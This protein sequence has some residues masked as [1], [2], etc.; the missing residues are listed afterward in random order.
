MLGVWTTPNTP[1]TLC[2]KAFPAIHVRC[3]QKS[4]ITPFENKYVLKGL[5]LH[6]HLEERL[7]YQ[8]EN[9]CSGSFIAF[10]LLNSHYFQRK[11]EEKAMF[12][13]II[14]IFLFYLQRIL[15]LINIT[16]AFPAIHV[17]CQQKTA[18]SYSLLYFF[19]MSWIIL[20]ISSRTLCGSKTSSFSLCHNSCW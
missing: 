18:M 14:R 15:I 7:Y 2:T 19:S 16:K 5:I 20:F 3:Q 17:R 9:G 13:L 11:H 1:Q 10:F 4:A 6:R 8:I 12:P